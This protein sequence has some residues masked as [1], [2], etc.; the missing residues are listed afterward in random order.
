MKQA[1]LMGVLDLENSLVPRVFT[2]K[3]LAML[4]MLT[5]Q[6]AIS[7]EKA[8]LQQENLVRKRAEEELRRSEGF[9]AQGETIGHI[10]SWGW[11][12]GT[13]FGL[14]VEGTFSDF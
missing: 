1:K 12:V 8:G 6:A 11:H 4:E 14:L 5:S 13:G 3:R 7:L 10:G 2:P 9:L